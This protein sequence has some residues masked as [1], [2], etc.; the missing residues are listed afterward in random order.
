LSAGLAFRKQ[1]AAD[2]RLVDAE[3]N[4]GKRELAILD[5]MLFAGL[6]LSPICFPIA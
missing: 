4:K 1:K 5:V 2:L 3:T 6:R